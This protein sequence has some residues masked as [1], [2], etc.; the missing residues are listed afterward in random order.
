[1]GE[2]AVTTTLSAGCSTAA[3]SID[4]AT[5][6]DLVNAAPSDMMGDALDGAGG[7]GDM[8]CVP[9]GPENC[10]NNIDDDCNGHTDC[11]DHACYATATCVPVADTTQF[12]YGTLLDGG[13][14]PCPQPAATTTKLFDDF[15]NNPA[16]CTGCACNVSSPS[17]CAVPYGTGTQAP[18]CLNPPDQSASSSIGTT[19]SSFTLSNVFTMYPCSSCG[20]CTFTSSTGTLPAPIMGV[21]EYC[22]SNPASVGGGCAPG[23]VCV[24]SVGSGGSNTACVIANAGASCPSG[25][26]NQRLL[27]TGFKDERT[28]SACGNCIDFCNVFLSTGSGCTGPTTQY[29]SPFNHISVCVT[30]A[31]YFGKV[32]YSSCSGSSGTTG[33]GMLHGDGTQKLVCCQ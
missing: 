13:T 1:M 18:M 23:S 21:D 6:G 16:S 24:P 11:D 26:G 32:A 9:T 4:L 19:C 30:A 28:C 20:S 17:T 8:V 22:A 2:E 15:D 14:A 31:S 5:A 29:G 25:Y 27:W 33:P 3:L 10:F 7:G 12:Q